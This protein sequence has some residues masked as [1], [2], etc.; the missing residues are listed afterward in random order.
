MN[1]N[2]EQPKNPEADGKLI[3]INEEGVRSE[4][5]ALVR[6]TVEETLNA[7]L[8]AEADEL[9]KASKYERSPERAS[10]RAG[11]YTRT[12][13]ATAGQLKLKVPRLRNVP[14]ETAIIER[15]KRREASVEESLIEMY[16]AGVSVR[17][18]EDITQALWGTRV[19][20]QTVSNLNQ[21]IYGK[22]DEW[23][24]RPL[25]GTYP[26]VYMDG[27]WLK[28]SWGGEVK[29]VSVLVALGV[30]EAGDREII[31]VSEGAKE[32]K[33]SWSGFLRELKERGL[34]GVRL[35]IS[36]KSLGLVES[37]PDFYPE[38]AWQRCAVHFY[39]D[40]MKTVPHT[41]VEEVMRLVKTIH[42]QESRSS[43]E[44]KAGFVA[45]KLKEM[46]LGK[47]ASIIEK[48]AS[49]T[50]SYYSFPPQHWKH[51]RTNNLLERINK[52]I[53]R[54]TR[55]VGSF[56]DAKSALM[57]VAARLRHIM[58]SKWGSVHYMNMQLL[59]EAEEKNELMA[60]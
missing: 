10:T 59:Y 8:D 19:S 58:A 37:L 17:R 54:R 2:T 51:I 18:V 9:C 28:R 41:K 5:G 26:Y 24:N 52:E 29:N 30:N 57:L 31:G 11:H 39:R 23:R 50:L 40:I 3:A 20:P 36:D 35:F 43:S 13:H 56:P 48:G 60:V 45:Q 33:D 25:E 16:L 42:S 49:E 6:Q 46:K 1:N 27:I 22:I 55:V 7:L 32:D 44:A 12:L 38:A 34:K 14:F 47:A 21:K 15:Y 4:L 53:R